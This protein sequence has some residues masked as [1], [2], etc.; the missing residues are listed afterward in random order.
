MYNVT[1]TD[2]S[3][4]EIYKN[5]RITQ[6]GTPNGTQQGKK[7]KEVNG[8]AK[9]MLTEALMRASIQNN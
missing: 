4:L 1:N 7:E 2:Q 6:N 3:N 8:K 5:S 9:K